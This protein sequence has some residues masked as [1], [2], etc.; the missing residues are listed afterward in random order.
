MSTPTNLKQREE[1]FEG[2]LDQLVFETRETELTPE[3]RRARRKLVKDDRLA[4]AKTY[5]PGVFTEDFNAVHRHMATLTTGRHSISGFPMSGKS[6]FGYFGIGMHEIAH[7]MG[8]ILACGARTQDIAVRNTKRFARVIKK[9]RM[10]KYD[11]GLEVIQ[12]SAGD[13]IFKSEEGQTHV[14][15]G[16]VNTGLR[17]IV[18]DDFNRIRFILLDDLYNKESVRSELDNKRV[19]EWVTGEAYRQMEYDGLAIW[20]GN[21]INEGCPINLH[22][23][24]FPDNHFSFPIL[25]EEGESNWPDRLSMEDIEEMKASIPADV[26]YSEY[27]DDPLEVGEEFDAS[28][29]TPMNTLGKTIIASITAVDPSHGSSPAACDKAAF[30]LGITPDHEVVCLGVYIR[31]EGYPKFFNYLRKVHLRTPNHR[32]ILFEDDFAQWSI[33]QPYYMQ[34]LEKEETPLPI[35]RHK[36]KDLASKHRA[37]DKDSRILTLVHPHQTGLFFYAKDV[38]ETSDFETYRRQY[39][40]YGRHGKKKLDGLDAAATAYLMIR[41]YISTGTFKPTGKRQRSRPTWDRGGW[42]I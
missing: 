39:M 11:F 31:K 10:L 1:L 30:T 42:H 12:D 2:F 13:Y 34:W 23:K 15:A 36:A 37:A 16:S 6:A 33:A 5:F 7:G 41:G 29:L 8:G 38:M 9:H 40:N 22:K 3:K 35:V 14:V 32:A 25:N 28:W 4:F 20:L 19:F 17:N 18:D 27:L 24:E 21:S 26:W